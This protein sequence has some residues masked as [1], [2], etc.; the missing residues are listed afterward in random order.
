MV[1]GA[2]QSQ[3]CGVVEIQ[4]VAHVVTLFCI[5]QLRF[6]SAKGESNRSEGG[7]SDYREYGGAQG[8]STCT[9]FV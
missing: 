6:D 9:V 8:I 7:G 4:T 1:N 2:V 3:C 5:K